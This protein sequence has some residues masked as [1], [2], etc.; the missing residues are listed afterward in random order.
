MKFA[1]FNG[2]LEDGSHNLVS[3]STLEVLLEDWQVLQLTE[4]ERMQE[5]VRGLIR[6]TILIFGKVW[7][8]IGTTL[9]G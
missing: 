2:W 8:W 3:W 4:M 9:D 1:K 5:M 6:T 7:S